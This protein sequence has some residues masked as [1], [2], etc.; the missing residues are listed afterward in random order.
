[1]KLRAITLAGVALVALTAGVGTAVAD[2]QDDA[3]RQLNLDQLEKA[4]S[5]DGNAQTMPAPS[6]K[7]GMGGPEF[8][9]RPGPDEGMTDDNGPGADDEDA[10]PPDSDAPDGDAEQ[11]N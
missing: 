6:Q 8:S 5:D 7:D 2:E 3:V 9:A 4:R 11:P 1:M 10:P